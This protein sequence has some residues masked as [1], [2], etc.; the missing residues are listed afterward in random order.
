M[1]TERNGPGGST[2]CMWI[3]RGIH[4]VKTGQESRG[5]CSTGE[6]HNEQGLGGL[7]DTIKSSSVCNDY[8]KQNKERLEQT[9]HM[10]MTCKIILVVNS[11]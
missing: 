11:T 2:K 5:L 1:R 7:K 6:R 4:S 9:M 8:K 10:K 3:S